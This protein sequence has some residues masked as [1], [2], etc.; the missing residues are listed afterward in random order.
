MTLRDSYKG[1]F[2]SATTEAIHLPETLEKNGIK[3]EAAIELIGFFES[4][5][6]DLVTK[7]DI[8]DMVTKQDL[9]RGLHT[10]EQNLMAT[11]QDLQRGL[12]TAEQ[13]LMATRQDLQQGLHTIEQNLNQKTG[14]LDQKIE[15]LSQKI[16]LLKQMI[17]SIR[18]G[19]AWL[20][21]SMIAGFTALLTVM[22]YLHSNTN[23]RLD[24]MEQ[25]NTERHKEVKELLQKR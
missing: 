12:H 20:K 2:M 14:L 22:L 21:W 16:E 25:R 9:Q 6:S 13:N 23:E 3:K 7:H 17:E 5:H 8:K 11:R 24:R 19:H 15:A 18:Q 4:R 1:D 10:A